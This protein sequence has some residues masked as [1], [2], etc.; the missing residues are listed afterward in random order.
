MTKVYVK[1]AEKCED[2]CSGDALKIYGKEYCVD[3]LLPILTE[4]K[5]FY[6]NSGGGV[7]ISGGECL[8]HADFCAELLEKLK[9]ENIHTAVDTC[10]FVS[11]E[12][13]DKV[14][15]YTDVFLYDVKA[16]D[17]YIHIECTGQSNKLILENL[18]YLDECGK[19]IEIRIPYVPEYNSGEMNRIFDFLKTL[20]N[21]VKI[22]ILPYHNY[23]ASKYEALS[24]K[25]TLPPKLPSAEKIEE[26]QNFCG[27]L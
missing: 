5:D 1:R 4:D 23:A 13:F 21:I 17:E 12:A 15:P 9:E 2:Y 16:F 19:K 20:K 25:N 7:T 22:R 27:T 10:G 24:M 14:M 3:E 11:R 6:D 18:K 8:L 26:L